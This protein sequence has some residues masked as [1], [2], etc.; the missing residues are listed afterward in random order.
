MVVIVVFVA[1]TA[2][3]AVVFILCRRNQ[4][5][6][7][8]SSSIE[9]PR[10]ITAH[11][12]ISVTE[13]NQAAGAGSTHTSPDRSTNGSTSGG[14][15]ADS[16]K[17]SFVR[18]DRQR[19]DMQDLL[20]ASAEILGSGCF[21]SS[22]K[23]ALLSGPVM[24]VKRFKQMNNVGREEFQEH[25]RRI[26]RLR[27]PNLLP[28]VAYYYKKEEK[29]LVS[30]YIQK[31]SLAVQLHG[32][33]SI[34]IILHKL[35][36]GND[37]MQYSIFTYIHILIIWCRKPSSGT[38]MPGLDNPVEDH[39]RSRQGTTISVQRASKPN[40]SSWPSQILKRPSQRELRTPSDGLRFDTSNQPRTWTGADGSI[41]VA[42]VRPIRE[43]NEEDRRVGTRNAN[44]RDANREIPSKIST[45]RERK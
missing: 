11:K 18:D 2:I 24:V 23:A 33:V 27:H 36:N 30:D 19:F 37:A 12:K 26:G 43:D 42:G 1:L 38:A 28:L 29:L 3:C 14:K 13:Q 31:G 45:E 10:P 9:A 44:T 17:L 40:S 21:G 8:S 25:M 34:I 7:S 39:Q 6:S 5:N 16:L 20:R 35:C 41:Q 15:K 4:Y 22:Y 32:M